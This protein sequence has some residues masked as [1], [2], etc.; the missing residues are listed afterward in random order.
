MINHRAGGP[1]LSGSPRCP[2]LGRV[3][4][5]GIEVDHDSLRPDHGHLMPA[6]PLLVRLKSGHRIAV[7]DD[8]ALLKEV[9]RAVVQVRRDATGL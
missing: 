2:D 3:R 7:L 8:V 4:G 5:T 6:P 9:Q 1:S